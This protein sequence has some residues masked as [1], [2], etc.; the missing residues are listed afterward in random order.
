MHVACTRQHTIRNYLLI[1]SAEIATFTN[2]ST[3]PYS[4][5]TRSAHFPRRPFHVLL[6]T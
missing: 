5:V 6:A 2:M 4:W 3:V 1:P